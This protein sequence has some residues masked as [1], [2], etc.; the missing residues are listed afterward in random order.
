M[1]NGALA[2][3]L[4]SAPH[5]V[6]AISLIPEI[7]WHE[8][9]SPVAYRWI[10]AAV[11]LFDSCS[12]DVPV[13]FHGIGLS[14]GSG[15]PLNFRHLEQVE[16]AVDRYRPTWYSEHLS[17]FRTTDGF[18]N[19]VHAAVGLPVPFDLP[20]LGHIGAQVA[21]VVSRLP[22]PFLLENSAIYVEVP[23][24]I[25]TEAGFL[26]RL[27]DQTGAGVLL[28]LHNLVVNEVNLKWNAEQFL[29]ELDLDHVLEVHVAGGEFMGR[30]YTDGHSGAC[31]E[32]V[33]D[34]LGSIA[35]DL[36]NLR[37]VTFEL[38]ESRFEDLGLDGLV[39]QLSRI[40]TSTGSI[41]S[42]VT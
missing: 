22:V 20:T 29:A 33:W 41:S 8:S 21:A 19:P 15:L 38:H 7:L 30:W 36:P 27:C 3:P 37:L 14:I 10:P 11:D 40:R 28:D 35:D 23:S 13:V 17:A 32:R 26:N 18:G 1:Y 24:S 42:N 16:I 4:A 9:S 34:L 12:V 2:E 5:V 25:M 39:R 6:D 31:P